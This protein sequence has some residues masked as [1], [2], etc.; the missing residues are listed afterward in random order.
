MQISGAPTAI[1]NRIVT[2]EVSSLL[3]ATIV[4]LLLSGDKKAGGLFGI[5]GQGA[6]D[7]V[8]GT[9]QIPPGGTVTV[10]MLLTDDTVTSVTLVMQDPVTDAELYRSAND[11]PVRLG[12]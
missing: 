4:P 3:G 10:A 8:A 2:C 12:V 7:R 6:A 9:V 11:I 1:T 5:H